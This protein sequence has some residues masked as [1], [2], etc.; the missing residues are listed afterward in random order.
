[1]VAHCTAGRSTCLR[2]SMTRIAPVTVPAEDSSAC[3]PSFTTVWQLLELQQ[4]AAAHYLHLTG[5]IDFCKAKGSGYVAHPA[6][7]DN[8]IQL[9]PISGSLDDPNAADASVTR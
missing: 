4:P 1:M 7:T 6:V 2:A 9:G 3:P 5:A 8:T